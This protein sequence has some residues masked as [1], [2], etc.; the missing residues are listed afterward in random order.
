MATKTPAARFA[1]AILTPLPV[2]VS[3][4][5]E[6]AQG[7]HGALTA[8]GDNGPGLHSDKAG[9]VFKTARDPLRGEGSQFWVLDGLSGCVQG[10]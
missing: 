7:V 8:E 9:E 4:E 10:C 3:V 5:G 1:P 2:A 6:Q